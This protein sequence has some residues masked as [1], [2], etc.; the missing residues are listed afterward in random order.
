ML[1]TEDLAAMTRLVHSGADAGT[2]EAAAAAI[3][4]QH[5]PHPDGQIE[6][7]AVAS[8]PEGPGGI[9]HKY[10]HSILFFPREGQT[11]HAY[12]SYCFRWPQFVGDNSLRFAE[13][14]QEVLREYLV[15]HESVTDVIFTGGDPLVMKS[16]TLGRYVNAALGQETPH[17]ETIRIG[18]KALSYWPYRFTDGEDSDDLIRLFDRIVTNGRRVAIMAHF[19]H[20]RELTTAPVQRAI[21]RIQS[22]GAAIYCQAPLIRHVNDCPTIWQEMWS[23]QARL[24]CIPYYMFVERPT[25]PCRYFDVPLV[26]AHAIFSEA[27]GSIPGLARTVR[28]P[29]MSAAPGKIVVDG[30]TRVGREEAF[31]LQFLQARDESWV[32]RPFLAKFDRD[33]TWIDQLSPLGDDQRFFFADEMDELWDNETE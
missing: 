25:G 9:Q 23:R 33:A 16:A 19:S 32:G 6:L 15:T 20:P 10:R 22:T 13:R 26:R 27:Y 28:G 11:C 17:V 29:V 1:P 5:N 14:D 24:D 21:Q 7:N 3:R 30:V 4:R 31:V 18:T 12:C 8:G 2:L